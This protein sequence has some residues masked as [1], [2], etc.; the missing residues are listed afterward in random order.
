MLFIFFAPFVFPKPVFPASLLLHTQSPALLRGSYQYPPFIPLQWENLS[1]RKMKH[2][3]EQPSDPEKRRKINP[4]GTLFIDIL[5]Q[6]ALF[7]GQ[8]RTDSSQGTNPF[9]LL[10]TG[11]RIKQIQTL[12]YNLIFVLRICLYLSSIRYK[13]SYVSGDH[14]SRNTPKAHAPD[15]A[16]NPP[17]CRSDRKKDEKQKTFQHSRTKNKDLSSGNPDT[18]FP[19]KSCFQKKDIQKHRKK[20]RI[21]RG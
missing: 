4:T 17:L 2:R 1:R 11:I 18:V 16:E 13:V 7:P 15:S 8:S 14:P 19:K 3:T 5:S 6:S 20:N 21:I 9:V 12:P 10:K